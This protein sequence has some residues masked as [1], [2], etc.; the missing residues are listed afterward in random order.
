MTTELELPAG[1]D[2]TLGWLLAQVFHGHMSASQRALEGFPGSQRGYMVVN[3]AVNGCARNQIDMAKQLRLDRT[4]MVYLVD[5][6]VE[7]GL[8]ERV[9]D[10]GDR[11]SKMIVA[12]DKGRARLEEATAVLCRVDDHV[13]APLEPGERAALREMLQRVAA[14][15]LATGGDYS[16]ACATAAAATDK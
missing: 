10:P 5:E 16:A 3:A 12:T 4:V 1:L 8:V 9:P 13:L 15:Y 2:E 14:H 11:R 7:A 6:L